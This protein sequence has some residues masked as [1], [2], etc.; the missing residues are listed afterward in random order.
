MLNFISACLRASRVVAVTIVAALT[1]RATAD[2]H[3]LAFQPVRDNT[4]YEN[5]FGAVSNGHGDHCFAGVTGL[6]SKRRALLVFD[7]SLIPPSAT[8][9]G[10]TLQLTLDRAAGASGVRPMPLHRVT[11][12]WGEGGS[13]PTDPFAG[14]GQGG[15][16]AADDATWLHRFFSTTQWASPGGDFLLA[17]SATTNVGETLGDYVWASTPAMVADVQQWLATPAQNFGW[18][19][20]GDESGGASARRFYTREAS[21][22]ALRPKLTVTFTSVTDAPVPAVPDL[23]FAPAWPNPFNPTTRLQWELPVVGRVR[24]TV[25]DVRG[26]LLATLVDGTQSAGPH[27]FMWDARDSHGAVLPSGVYV[28]RVEQGS[29]VRTQRVALVR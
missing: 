8:I 24:A 16:A 1:V 4:L 7:L 9:T 27:A 13:E 19:L 15:P 21:T 3:T 12:S 5:A 2:A 18:V 11:A 20:I 29:K 17:E 6:D 26:A 23:V 10:V 25:H 28:V 14:G 22:P